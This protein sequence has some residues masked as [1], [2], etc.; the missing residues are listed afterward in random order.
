MKIWGV[1]SRYLY[2]SV[3]WEKQETSVFLGSRKFQSKFVTGSHGYK[4]IKLSRIHTQLP[5][6]IF[7][8]NRKC[9]YYNRWIRHWGNKGQGDPHRCNAKNALQQMPNLQ[10]F[11]MTTIH[12]RVQS[13]HVSA[14]HFHTTRRGRSKRKTLQSDFMNEAQCFLPLL[15]IAPLSAPHNRHLSRLRMP[16]KILEK[17]KRRSYAF[18]FSLLS[19][20]IL[21]IGLRT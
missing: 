5:V 14:L 21:G 2:P 17:L 15:K 20:G 10:I 4:H 18:I 9:W 1:C 6:V 16:M 13:I 11:C 12:T 7:K 19:S 8:L 3:N